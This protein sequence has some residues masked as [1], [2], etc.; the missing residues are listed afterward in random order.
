MRTATT[1]PAQE[2]QLFS[3][4]VHITDEKST[5]DE[6]SAHNGMKYAQYT[7]CGEK[8]VCCRS[9]QGIKDA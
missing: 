8:A 7:A 2:K 4:G 6:M 1:I 5:A 9:H 3:N